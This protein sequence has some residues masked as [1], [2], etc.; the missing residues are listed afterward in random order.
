M[1]SLT[2]S[3]LQWRKESGP[4]LVLCFKAGTTYS[5]QKV[6]KSHEKF[7]IFYKAFAV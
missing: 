2:P 7:I 3:M 5:G 6:I 4:Y 1:F